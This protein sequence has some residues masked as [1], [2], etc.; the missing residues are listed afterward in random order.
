ME[1]MRNE[2]KDATGRGRKRRGERRGNER[3]DRGGGEFH[4]CAD[5]NAGR[6]DTE[7]EE[8]EEKEHEEDEE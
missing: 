4:E 2:S 7:A 5:G 8:E 3:V 6:E 1:G